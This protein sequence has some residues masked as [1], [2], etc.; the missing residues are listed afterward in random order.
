MRD[1]RIVSSLRIIVHQ[2]RM[3]G[4]ELMPRKLDFASL[5]LLVD[6]YPPYVMM[7][8]FTVHATTPRNHTRIG[9]VRVLATP[10]ND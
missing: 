9:N 7:T 6:L 1:C 3:I 5:Q 4:V 2:I 10:K 8:S